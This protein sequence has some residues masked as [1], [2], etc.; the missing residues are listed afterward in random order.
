MKM[1]VAYDQNGRI[2]AA[3]TE[4]GDRPDDMIGMTIEELD[5]PREFEKAE[6]HKFFHLLR[7]DVDKRKLI[8]SK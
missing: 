2:L 1:Y 4:E 3:G 6:P 8:K 7:V 5:V